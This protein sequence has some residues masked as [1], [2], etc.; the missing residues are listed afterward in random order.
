[1]RGA[2]DQE[3]RGAKEGTEARILDPPFCSGLLFHRQTIQFSEHYS[4]SSSRDLFAVG[5][6]CLS[7]RR[8]FMVSIRKTARSCVEPRGPSSGQNHVRQSFSCLRLIAPRLN[9]RSGSHK[10]PCLV[11]PTV[12]GA[13]LEP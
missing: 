10:R 6:D 13:S 5:I 2:T 12:D 8:H 3:G 4:S 9:F 7:V 1:M 11:A